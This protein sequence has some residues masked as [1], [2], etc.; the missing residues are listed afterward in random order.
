MR[1][2]VKR[3]CG[4]PS[5][6]AALCALISGA[7]LAEIMPLPEPIPSPLRIAFDRLNAVIDACCQE[8]QL[9]A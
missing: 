5:T 4:V 2:R 9:A 6:A 3:G 7:L 8:E 1:N